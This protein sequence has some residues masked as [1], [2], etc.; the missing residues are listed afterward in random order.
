M[1]SRHAGRRTVDGA[2]VFASNHSLHPGKRGGGGMMSRKLM[3][4]AGGNSS[5][6]A[7][8]KEARTEG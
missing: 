2:R 7:A 6:K 8:L 5:D 4:G 3:N 1:D